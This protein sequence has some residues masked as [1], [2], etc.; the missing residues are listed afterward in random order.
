TDPTVNEQDTTLIAIIIFQQFP[1]KDDL[2]RFDY[3]KVIHL[4][5]GVEHCLRDIISRVGSVA[6]QENVSLDADS[7]SFGKGLREL[8]SY[9]ADFIEVLRK[10]DRVFGGLYVP[11]HRG[12]RLIAIQQDLD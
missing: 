10:R 5:S 4:T 9:R 12:E 1:G 6:I 7:T 3:A 8:V 2:W 11:Q